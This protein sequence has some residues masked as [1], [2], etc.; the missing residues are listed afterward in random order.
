MRKL[1]LLLLL[2]GP[3]W[4]GAT[5]IW[6]GQS[7]GV[8]L[9]WTASSLTARASGAARAVSLV[10]LPAAKELEGCE[11]SREVKVLSV[12]GPLVS[13]DSAEG[14]SCE[15]AAHGSEVRQFE[16]VDA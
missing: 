10:T 4:A 1:V 16:V 14:L 3:A 13:Y 9:E 7:G 6:R 5:P 11:G 15:G 12:V 8:Q 2:A